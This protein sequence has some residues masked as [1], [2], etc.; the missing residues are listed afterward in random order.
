MLVLNQ[1]QEKKLIRY[2]RRYINKYN[3]ILRD[4]E[5]SINKDN[6]IIN[7]ISVC[8]KKVFDFNVYNTYEKLKY[9]LYEYAKDFIKTSKSMRY[10]L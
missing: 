5:V 6:V 10:K 7:F 8:I 9:C 3:Y 1:E 2:F 4:F